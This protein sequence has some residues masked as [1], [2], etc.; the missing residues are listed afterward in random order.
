MDAEREAGAD[1]SGEGGGRMEADGSGGEGGG[2]MEADGIG[3]A[4]GGA[5]RQTEA[6]AERRR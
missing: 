4:E 2:G 3:E 6:K 1:G 5:E